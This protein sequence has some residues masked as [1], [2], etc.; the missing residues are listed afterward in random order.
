M[1]TR[2]KANNTTALN[3]TGSWVG[4]VVPTSVDTA[5]WNSTVTGA[6][7]VALGANAS[8]LGLTISNP[9]GNVTIGTTAATLTLG[10][11]GIDMSAS[12]RDL[13]I[14]SPVAIS[15]VSGQP[16]NVAANRTLAVS[17]TISGNNLSINTLNSTMTGN[18]FLT[19]G[20]GAVSGT[21]NISYGALFV[22]SFASGYPN[23]I[24]T[25][26]TTAASLSNNASVYICGGLTYNW[27]GNIS[28]VG[29][30]YVRN[31]SSN[32]VVFLGT[33]SSYTGS[34]RLY[35]DSAEGANVTQ[36][37]AFTNSAQL[38]FGN[39]YFLSG[40]GLTTLSQTLAYT[41][42]G[43][44]T[45]GAPLFIQPGSGTVTAIYDNSSSNGGA[46]TNSNVVWL[47]NSVN[48]T[49]RVAATNGSITLSNQVQEQS[50]GILS[51][52]KTGNSA[53]TLSGVCNYRGA[54][55]VSAGTLNANSAT[56]LGAAS[57]T[58]AISVS[59]GATL[60]LAAGTTMTYSSRNLAIAADGTSFFVGSLVLS[61]A[62]TYTF[63]SI[64]IASNNTFIRSTANATLAGN[65]ANGG[66]LIIMGS[67]GTSAAAATSLTVNSIISGTGGLAFGNSSLDTLGT[68]ILSGTN[69][70]QGNTTFGG[71]TARANNNSAFGTGTLVFTGGAID[72]SA[73]RT[74][75]NAITV[76]SNITFGGTAALTLSANIA[77]GASRVITTNGS[78][79]ALTL[80]GVV[81]GAT[82]K[83]TKAGTN[84][85]TLTNAN[86][87][88]G[89]TDIGAGTL[90]AGN[91]QALSTSGTVTLTASGATLQ[92]LTTGGQNGKLT[93]AALTNSAGGTIKIGG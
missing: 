32:G 47:T 45:L 41:G 59:S 36:R 52:S 20:A 49:F 17:S 61:D 1:A 13:I 10:I 79:G 12:T 23:Q 87:Y 75:S 65:I 26:S 35:A 92:T 80:S 78:G 68:V 40:S 93:V 22:G 6:N 56:A 54:V 16:W 83:L 14:S 7:T 48:A 21:V 72:T 33:M 89:G 44:L 5:L 71:G 29:D 19:G 46:V 88:S 4:G 84:T 18:V 53:A 31:T 69:T 9:G 81:S 3:L 11:N 63:G 58:A 37:A 82:F 86:T 55:T 90:K 24:E 27:Y 73:T 34:F 43:N 50:T 60:S 76:S 62:N 38:A 8:W 57:S 91:T 25:T 64:S 28:G 30:L 2:T 51:L 77:L 67:G 42:S 66:N 85:L 74:F 39:F 15:W 70:Y